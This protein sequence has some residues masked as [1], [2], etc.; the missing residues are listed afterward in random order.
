MNTTRALA[1]IIATVQSLNLPADQRDAIMA[2]LWTVRG[3]TYAGQ[4]EAIARW[5]DC[6]ATWPTVA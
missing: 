1:R 5:R 3:L 4:V 6:M 2:E